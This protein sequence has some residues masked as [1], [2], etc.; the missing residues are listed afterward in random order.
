MVGPT[1]RI[2][3]ERR[4]YALI[5]ERKLVRACEIC[6]LEGGPA[7]DERSLPKWLRLLSSMGCRSKRAI[8]PP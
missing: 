2:A 5:S 6:S 4:R 1:D 8:S 3:T 7:L